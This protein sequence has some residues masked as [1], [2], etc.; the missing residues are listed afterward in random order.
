MNDLSKDAVNWLAVLEDGQGQRVD[1]YLV[2][3]LKGVPKSHIYRILRSG[4]VRVNRQKVGPDTR[5]N[6]GDQLR[7]PPIRASAPSRKPAV[8]STRAVALPPIL[9][10]DDALL[11]LDKP[12]GLAVHGGSGISYGVIER[13]RLARPDAAFLEL[14]HRLDRETSGVLLVAKK[15]LALTGL[16]AQLRDGAIDK[17]YSVLVRGKW[18]DALRAVEMPLST[19]VTGD[20]ERRVRADKDGRLART[21]F[22]RVEVWPRADP[23]VALLDAELETGRTHQIRVHLTELGFPLAGDDKYGDFAWNK[24]LARHG[25]KRMFLH[26]YRIRFAHPLTGSEVVV[27]APLAPDLAAFIARLSAEKKALPDAVGR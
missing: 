11:A 2:K 3:V 1:N 22:R 18:R 20:G 7:I 23:P 6:V 21:I 13:L 24:V 10:E 15:R 17:R 14:V 16:H 19:Y 27:E 12:A 8:A 5:L 25:L 4:E 9:F 26:A